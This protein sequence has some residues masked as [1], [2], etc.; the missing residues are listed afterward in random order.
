[1]YCNNYKCIFYKDCSL[2]LENI[3]V[4]CFY[5]LNTNKVNIEEGYML[6][7][8]IIVN[9]LTDLFPFSS[10]CFKIHFIKDIDL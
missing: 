8:M 5:Y 9:V 7:F 4:N 3:F 2:Y 1:M 6:V 10:M